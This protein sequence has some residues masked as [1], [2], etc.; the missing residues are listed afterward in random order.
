MR[1]PDRETTIGRD[2]TGKEISGPQTICKESDEILDPDQGKEEAIIGQWK[3][4]TITGQWKDGIITGQWKEEIQCRESD[5]ITCHQMNEGNQCRE[6]DKITGHHMNE[7]SQ[8]RENRES[9]CH[10]HLLTE[11]IHSNE[12]YEMQLMGDQE[13]QLDEKGDDTFQ[14]PK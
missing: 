4:R 13:K 2:L 14:I 3:G 11:E 9:G 12:T 5:E 6:G 1:D 7:G 8:C 10:L